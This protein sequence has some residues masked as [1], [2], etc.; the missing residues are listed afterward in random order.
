MAKIL[1]IDDDPVLLKLYSTRLMADKHEVKTASNGESALELLS[2]FTPELIVADL[3]M[4]KLNGF[5]FLEQLNQQPKF[6]KTIRIVFSSVVNEE[7]IG[8][9]EAL[10]VSKYLNKTD[11]TPTQL[12]ETINQLLPKSNTG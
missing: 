3:L 6:A 12:V 5:S 7:Q 10:K 4:P 8:R 1:L 9:L 2:D 11:T